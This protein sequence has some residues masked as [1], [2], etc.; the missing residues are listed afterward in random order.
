MRIRLRQSR[1]VG[2]YR[3]NSDLAFAPTYKVTFT[4]AMNLLH[5]GSAIAV[6]NATAVQL[7]MTDRYYSPEG[8][9]QSERPWN[10]RDRSAKIGEQV[11]HDALDGSRHAK[12]LIEGWAENA[13]G[14]VVSGAMSQ[15]VAEVAP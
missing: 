11:M 8:A 15:V 4:E 12:S 10:M 5:E 3:L 1:W 6:N 7:I 2:V 14:L 9:P 13:A